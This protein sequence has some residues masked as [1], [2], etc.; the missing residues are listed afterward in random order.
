[1][2]KRDLDDNLK[3]RSKEAEAE[4]LKKKIEELRRSVGDMKYET[5]LAEKRDLQNK[6][7]TIRREVITVIVKLLTKE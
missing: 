7:E 5:L 4:V 3:L 1:M 2:K 6:E